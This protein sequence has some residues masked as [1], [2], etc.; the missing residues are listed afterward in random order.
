MALKS[1]PLVIGAV[2]K[3][4]MQKPYGCSSL[5]LKAT[6]KQNRAQGIYRG[7]FASSVSVVRSSRGKIGA[8]RDA[9]RPA[10]APQQRACADLVGTRSCKIGFIERPEA[11]NPTATASAARCCRTARCC[12]ISS[13]E[14]S[15]RW[16]DRSNLAVA[17]CQSRHSPGLLRQPR[18]SQIP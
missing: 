13:T 14:E 17:Q 1:K 9:L 16:P 2:G 6:V 7:H 12:S 15:R 10:D 11:L 8:K 18:S 3:D 4:T 5:C